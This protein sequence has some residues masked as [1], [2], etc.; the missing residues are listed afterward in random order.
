M[1]GNRVRMTK[2]CA[3]SKNRKCV[4]IIHY[5]TIRSALQSRTNL[6]KVSAGQCVVFDLAKVDKSP[7]VARIGSL[8]RITLAIEFDVFVSQQCCAGGRCYP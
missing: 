8:H 6:L 7:I 5:V 4:T 3:Q 1:N 2:L